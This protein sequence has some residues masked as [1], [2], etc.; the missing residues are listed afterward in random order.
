[1]ETGRYTLYRVT[2][3]LVTISDFLQFLLVIL[4]IDRQV[5][6]TGQCELS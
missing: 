2:G 5:T 3:N 1:M 6:V 4:V